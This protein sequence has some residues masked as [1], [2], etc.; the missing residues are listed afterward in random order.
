GVAVYDSSPYAGQ[1][2]WFQ[3]GGTSCG[4]PQWA[5]LAAIAN[6][7]RATQN[8]PALTGSEG[9]LYD[10]SKASP[11]NYNDITTGSRAKAG[12]DYST[13]LGTPVADNLI[14]ALA[15]AP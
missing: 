14:N 4:P 3:V 2:G 10:A 9:V 8:K 13:G 5:G 7:M 11:N 15:P 6:S 12:Y 1:A